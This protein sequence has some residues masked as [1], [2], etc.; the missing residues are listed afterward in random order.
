MPQQVAPIQPLTAAQIARAKI[1][2][3]PAL[4]FATCAKILDKQRN[5]VRPVPNILQIRMDQVYEICQELGIPCKMLVLKPRQTG[6]STKAAHT[7]YHHM[8]RHNAWGA[9][10]ADDF[11]NSNNLFRIFGRYASTDEFDWGFSFAC[12]SKELAFANGSLMEQDT[13][14]NPK[15]G[16]ST[17]RQ[18]LHLS[19]VAKYPTDGQRD[20]KTTISNML[21]SFSGTG[22][23]ALCIAETTA[24]GASGWFYEQWAG[25]DDQP[26]AAWIEDYL[27]GRT[28]NGWI[29]VFAAW[30]EFED[31]RC[32]RDNPEHLEYFNDSN[33]AFH[34]YTLRERIGREKFGWTPEQVAWRRFTIASECGGDERIF[35]MHYP[36]DPESCFLASGTPRFDAA[37]ME[38]LTQLAKMER[39]RYGILNAAENDPRAV[40]F[41]ETTESEAWVQIH[42]LPRAGFRYILVCDPSTG[43]EEQSGADPDRHSAILFRVPCRDDEGREL[44]MRI[45]ARIMAPCFLDTDVLAKLMIHM[46]HFYGSCCTVVERNMG[47]L[48]ISLLKSAGVELYVQQRLDRVTSKMEIYYGFKT[49]KESRKAAIDRL[50]AMT[51]ETTTENPRIILDEHTVREMRTFI[52]TEKGRYESRSGCHDDDVL[53]TAIAVSCMENATLYRE[54]LR[55]RRGPADRKAWRRLG[56]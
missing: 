38:A 52:R 37:G 41:T 54:K 8:R 43:G 39:P 12:K 45:A 21:A 9:M 3:S 4:H 16:I 32:S 53:C 29:K 35:D 17:T 47:Q 56:R 6:C 31:H 5:V 28:G 50:A 20:A 46:H 40:S 1:L 14:L 11:G 30:H 26:G 55:R 44:P 15:A 24:E 42:E 22:K 48:L 51:R 49:D 25:K 36:D 10:M 2:R 27:D 7:C 33:P 18:V 23:N 13:A 34:R 19:E